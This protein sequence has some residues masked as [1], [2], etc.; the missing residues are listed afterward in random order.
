[1]DSPKNSPILV[2]IYLL[3]TVLSL[4]HYCASNAQEIK[5]E[6]IIDIF[7]IEKETVTRRNITLKNGEEEISH[8]PHV[9]TIKIVS[10]KDFIKRVAEKNEAILSQLLDYQISTEV[11]VREKSI[12]EPSFTT[13]YQHSANKDKRYLHE[14]YSYLSSNE[15]EEINKNYS[16]GIEARV[17]TGASVKFDYTT[18]A[19]NDLLLKDIERYKSSVGVIMSQPLLKGSGM[20]ATANINVAEADAEIV[21]QEYRKKM[22][23]VVLNALAT[24]WD[25]YRAQEALT[26]RKNSVKIAEQILKDNRQR[27]QLGKMAHTEVLEAEA[28]LAKRKSQESK[29]QQD[30]IAA[31]NSMFSYISA[32]PGEVEIG[33]SFEEEIKNKTFSPDFTSS[34]KKALQHRPEYLAAKRGIEKE[35]IQVIFAKNQRWPQ[36]DLKGSYGFNG[37]GDSVRDSLDAM[38]ES[39]YRTWT[40]G[41]ELTIPL[42]GGMKSRSELAS[43]LYRKKRSLLELKSVEVD[44]SNTIDTAIQNVYSTQEQ[45][46]YYENVKKLNQRLL[47]VELAMLEAGKSNSRLVLDKE[48][49]LIDAQESELGSFIE[50]EKSFLLLEA[51]EGILLRSYNVEVV[52]EGADLKK[53]ESEQKQ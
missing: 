18:L 16:A 41:A 10:M 6:V 52:K 21:F 48:E 3:C 44:I 12:F 53:W 24:G 1:M 4:F 47:D 39:D 36:L 35:D 51:T 26:I 7:H 38:V 19:S 30:L 9:S 43:A 33:I 14:Q 2:I 11:I 40:V 49:D 15:I 8:D 17:P 46:R 31:R 29:A 23:Q 34:I 32:S 20:A 50:N 5:G 42:L 13:S 28:G 22:L 45:L 25:Y 27:A 37:F